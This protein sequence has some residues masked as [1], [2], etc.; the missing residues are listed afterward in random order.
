MVNV[1][2]AWKQS[3]LPKLGVKVYVAAG[4]IAGITSCPAKIGLLKPECGVICVGS[5]DFSES[6][7]AAT[8]EPSRQ[9]IIRMAYWMI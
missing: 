2:Y 5:N 8:Y 7:K 1:R 6:G 3:A 4:N 9:A